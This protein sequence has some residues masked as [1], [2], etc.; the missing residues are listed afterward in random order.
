MSLLKKY[1][2]K[3]AIEDRIVMTWVLCVA[4]IFSVS[5]VAFVNESVDMIVIS[6]MLLTVVTIYLHHYLIEG[7]E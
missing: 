5:Y 7:E 2:F 4:M 3:I 6:G 1:W